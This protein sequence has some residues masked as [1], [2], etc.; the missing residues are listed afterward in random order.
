[1]STTAA[2]PQ[3]VVVGDQSSG[4]SSVLEGLTGF[5][6]SR[7]AKLCTRYATQITCRCEDEESIMVSIMPNLDAPPQEQQR[8]KTFQRTLT[9]MCPKNLVKLFKEAN[10]AMGI[11]TATNTTLPNGTRLPA[12]SEHE[13][14]FTAIDVPDIFRKETDSV[15]TESDIE[16]VMNMVNKYKILK[17]AKKADPT[18]IRTMAVAI[19]HVMG[20]RSDLTLGYYIVKNR[21]PDDANKSLK[22]GQADERIFFAKDPWFVV[23]STRKAG[24]DALKLRVRELLIDL[25]KEFPKLKTKIVGERTQDETGPKQ[26]T[27]GI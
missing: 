12:F 14:H 2:L 24:M 3:L 26:P 10:E 15:T 23:N 25:I 18:L 9:E 6:L 7:D 13:E 17:L 27:V 16:L 20:K 5:A 19:D 21:G 11:Q 1:M 22:Q 8:V 4:K